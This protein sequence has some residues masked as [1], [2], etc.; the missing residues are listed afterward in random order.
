MEIRK[1]IDSLNAPSNHK[2]LSAIVKL[3]DTDQ[4]ITI[5][6]IADN[7]E[8]WWSYWDSKGFIFNEEAC[9]VHQKLNDENDFDI[10]T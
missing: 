5:A 3:N 9:L 8:T 7:I 10:V 1:N 6:G 2:S 4:R